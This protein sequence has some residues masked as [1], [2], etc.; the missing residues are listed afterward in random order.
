MKKR[1][2]EIYKFND[3]FHFNPRISL[4]LLKD[5]FDTM[6]KNSKDY[7]DLVRI[8]KNQNVFA[9]TPNCNSFF[10]FFF[11][12]PKIRTFDNFF[13]SKLRFWS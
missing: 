6:N 2:L 3:A 12:T 13:L 8:V 9:K 4:E 10:F 5:K 11:R 1:E 7:I